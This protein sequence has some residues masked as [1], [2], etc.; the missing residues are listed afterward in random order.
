MNSCDTTTFGIL[1][2]TACI[3]KL[4]PPDKKGDM[5]GEMQ[6]NVTEA[7]RFHVSI[8]FRAKGKIRP[9]M[10]SACCFWLIIQNCRFE[11]KKKEIK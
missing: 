9:L 11:L 6:A 2:N 3:E 4:E 7:W 8:K 10:E 1:V 5:S